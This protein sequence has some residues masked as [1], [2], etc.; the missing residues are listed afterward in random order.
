MVLEQEQRTDAKQIR[1]RN[2]IKY[3][4]LVQAVFIDQNGNHQKKRGTKIY[5]DFEIS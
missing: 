3:G 5:L 1:K 4:K 2:C